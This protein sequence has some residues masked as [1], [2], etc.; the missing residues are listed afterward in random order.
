M[1]PLFDCSRAIHWAGWT[2]DGTLGLRTSALRSS[3]ARRISS[4]NGGV[5]NTLVQSRRF[6][7]HRVAAVLNSLELLRLAAYVGVF[8]AEIWGAN[9]LIFLN[10]Q[11]ANDS[12][13]GTALFNRSEEANAHQQAEIA[14]AI[15]V[16]VAVDVSGCELFPLR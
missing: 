1:D 6:L 13:R 7:W 8:R 16:Q 3:A 11:V 12:P 4:W 10:R 9:L 5:S 2:R 15:K 14:I